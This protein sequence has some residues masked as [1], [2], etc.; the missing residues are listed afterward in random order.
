M[1]SEELGTFA[2]SVAIPFDA[3]RFFQLFR[4]EIVSLSQK[5]CENSAKNSCVLTQL[6]PLLMANHI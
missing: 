6:H 1:G 3:E 5:I 4:F 2:V